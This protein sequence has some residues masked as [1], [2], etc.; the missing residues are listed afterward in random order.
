MSR[1][2]GNPL[3]SVRSLVSKLPEIVTLPLV[4]GRPCLNFANTVHGRLDPKTRNDT[5][6]SYSDL[7]AF[8]LR[9]NIISVE[10]YT[11]LYK[12]AIEVPREAERIFN[13]A[14]AFRNTLIQIIDTL[15]MTSDQ[16]AEDFLPPDMLN[17]VDVARRQAHLNDSL[18]WDGLQCI[19]RP[20]PEKEG[21]DLPLLE[22][23]R[24]AEALLCS[25]QIMKINT[26]SAPGC[27]W[28]YLDASKNHS[29]R[30]CSM[31]LCGNREK[32]TRFQR[33]HES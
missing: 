8:S 3:S 12:Y 11:K 23:V 31:K 4:G 21:L 24:D 6:G 20:H 25:P 14:R 26:C 13:A 19:L 5:L 33:K 29:R 17:S 32:A 30:W 22:I 27:G 10:T 16:K 15:A 2:P 9:Q 7:L 18:E 28:V 1:K